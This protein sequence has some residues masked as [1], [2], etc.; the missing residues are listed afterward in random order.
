MQYSKNNLQTS[1]DDNSYYR[2]LKKK[3]KKEYPE[4]NAIIYNWMNGNFHKMHQ[5]PKFTYYE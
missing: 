5:N 2:K 4:P 3:E 1:V